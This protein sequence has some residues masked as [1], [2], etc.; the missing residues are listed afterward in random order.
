MLQTWPAGAPRM[1]QRSPGGGYHFEGGFVG[2]LQICYDLCSGELSV[3]G[4]VWAGGGVV[5]KGLFG[6]EGWWG[7]YVFAEKEFGRWKLDFMPKVSCGTCAPG[8][9]PD[10][11]DDGAHWGA[12]FAPFPV[13]IKPGEKASLKKAGIEVGVLLT[14]H[15]MRCDADVEVIALVDLTKYLGPLGAAVASAGELAT[16]MG[17]KWNIEVSCGVGVAV[18]GNVHLCKSVPGGGIAG[19][20]SDSAKICGGG[21]VGC[22]IGLGKNKAELHMA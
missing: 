6:G 21:Y 5:T 14:P 8:C 10:E 11:H 22:G 13:M 9:K 3:V 20:T 2:A 17:K 15:P 7:A 16:E 18:S 4:W 19:I 12:G 1:L